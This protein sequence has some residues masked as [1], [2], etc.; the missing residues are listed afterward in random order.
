M[1]LLDACHL[2]LDTNRILYLTGDV[3]HYERQASPCTL[4]PSRAS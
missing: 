2:S 3:H 1:Q 4:R